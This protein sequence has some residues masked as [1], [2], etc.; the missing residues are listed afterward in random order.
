[1][2]YG[3]TVRFITCMFQYFLNRWNTFTS[4]CKK[5]RSTFK[6]KCIAFET[7]FNK[8]KKKK[9]K[10][11]TNMITEYFVVNWVNVL[12]KGWQLDAFSP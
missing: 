5:Y 4:I 9:K 2:E 6:G 3:I 8:K 11:C 10:K 12:I 7:L 1:M